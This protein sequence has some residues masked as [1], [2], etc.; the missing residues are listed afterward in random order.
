MKNSSGGRENCVHTRLQFF[1]SHLAPALA[2]RCGTTHQT[3]RKRERASELLQ[4]EN[5]FPTSVWADAVWRKAEATH[6]ITFHNFVIE[7]RERALQCFFFSFS[8]L[9]FV[10]NWKLKGKCDYIARG[11]QR[12]GNRRAREKLLINYQFR[13]LTCSHVFSITSHL[14]KS[15]TFVSA[16]ADQAGK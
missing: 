16:D 13:Y 15:Y 7:S 9:V 1:F 11:R 10:R 8:S 3:V 5:V 4:K 14:K 2:T 12:G 6:K